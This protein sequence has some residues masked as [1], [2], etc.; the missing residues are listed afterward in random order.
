MR[1][2]YPQVS[3]Q[4]V[5]VTEELLLS[6]LD[7]PEFQ[8][9]TFVNKVA[10]MKRAFEATNQIFEGTF[11]LENATTEL[12]STEASYCHSQLSYSGGYSA[13]CAPQGAF[14]SLHIRLDHDEGPPKSGHSLNV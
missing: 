9:A 10:A 4:P 2:D 13:F 8:S 11:G 3:D 12:C 14:D 7:L 1:Q 6:V 5:Q